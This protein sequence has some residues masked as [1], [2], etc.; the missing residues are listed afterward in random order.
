MRISDLLAM[1]F[2]KEYTEE[3]L[4]SLFGDGDFT[5]REIVECDIPLGHKAFCLLRPEFMRESDIRSVAMD[6]LTRS[7]SEITED[8][9]QTLLLVG[10]EN[11]RDVMSGV[12]KTFRLYRKQNK[13]LPDETEWLLSEIVKCLQ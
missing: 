5:W 6:F 8:Y 1:N 13:N 10:S 7:E 11:I 3:K 9:T 2:C 4:R 12:Y